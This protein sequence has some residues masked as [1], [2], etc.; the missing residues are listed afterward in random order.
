MLLS[1]DE[2]SPTLESDLY[3]HPG[4]LIRRAH[5]ISVAN[6]H[7]RFGRGVTPVQYAALRAVH[8]S[9]GMDQ[10]SLAQKIALDPTTTAGI[11]SRLEDKGWLLRE[12][13]PRRQRKLTLTE[14]GEDYLEQLMPGVAAVKHSIFSKMGKE[15]SEEFLRLLR[16]FVEVNSR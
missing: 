4:Y 9:P 2:L 16:K 14:A 13:L 3:S 12:I 15:D 5:Q 6:F 11:A 10:L 1:D 8:D 7:D